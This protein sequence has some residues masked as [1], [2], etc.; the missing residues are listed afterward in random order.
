M[1]VC[2]Y[3][4]EKMRPVRTACM[5]GV[6]AEAVLKVGNWSWKSVSEGVGNSSAV[7]E[8]LVIFEADPGFI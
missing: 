8:E 7:L 1:E 5:R 3:E 6:G 2:Y 4:D